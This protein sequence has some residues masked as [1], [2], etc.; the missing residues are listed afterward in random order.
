M[1]SIFVPCGVYNAIFE[2]GYGFYGNPCIWEAGEPL[3]RREKSQELS[4]AQGE[5]DLVAV[6]IPKYTIIHEVATTN[7]AD[8]ADASA[9]PS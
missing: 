2:F 1:M 7:A 5:W 4:D 8:A 3:F 9:N 6:G